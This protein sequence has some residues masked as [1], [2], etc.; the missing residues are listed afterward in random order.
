MTLELVR[1]DCRL[2]HGQ[3]LEAWVPYIGSDFLVVANND[4]ASD[5][6]YGSIM[7]IAVP[8][9]IGV[10]I[11]TLDDAVSGFAN[12]SWRHKKVILLLSDLKDALYCLRAGL[13]YSALNLGN[14]YCAPGKKQ[15]TCSVSLGRSDFEYL[16]E[17]Q[18]H[19][20]KIEAR[21]VPAV[22]SPNFSEII[23]R[24]DYYCPLPNEPV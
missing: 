24:A 15:I 12:G 13:D 18:Q 8:P 4:V 5:K 7:A 20:V 19:G 21:P 22:Q 1:V 23:G 10:E 9:S 16:K 2:I 14:L 6:L 3:V 11:V 17:I